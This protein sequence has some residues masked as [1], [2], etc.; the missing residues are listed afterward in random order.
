MQPNI[1]DILPL[2]IASDYTGGK[3]ARKN[4]MRRSTALDKE[5]V[6]NVQA[7]LS[8]VHSWNCFPGQVAGDAESLRLGAPNHILGLC[9]VQFKEAYVD[10]ATFMDDQRRA[11]ANCIETKSANCYF[12]Q[13]LEVMTLREPVEAVRR[14]SV[15]QAVH[16][17]ADCQ[18]IHNN[19]SKH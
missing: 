7:K 10:E 11:M 5:Y 18:P 8:R 6:G 19:Y 9:L 4:Y 15:Q 17:L 2:F 14:G 12:L 3:H 16:A 13:I 1:D